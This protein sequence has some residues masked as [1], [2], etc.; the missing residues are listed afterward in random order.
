MQKGLARLMGRMN[1]P[2]YSVGDAMS[3]VTTQSYFYDIIYLPSGLFA[4]V[5]LRRK[6]RY[7]IPCNNATF[8]DLVKMGMPCSY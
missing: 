7:R 2:G 8:R 6:S 1:L 3:N 5:S 4:F